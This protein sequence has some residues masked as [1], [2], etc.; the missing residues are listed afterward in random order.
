M[1]AKRLDQQSAHLEMIW[2]NVAELAKAGDVTTEEVE[3]AKARLRLFD[4]H[5][6]IKN[7]KEG[8]AAHIVLPR[9]PSPSDDSGDI[10]G[11]VLPVAQVEQLFAT[12]LEV[13]SLGCASGGSEP[14]E[15]CQSLV[16]FA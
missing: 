10:T 5:T 7:L 8:I 12:P 4:E 3:D 14:D 6:P 15:F 2:S 9:S 16:D 1:G 13:T 11:Q